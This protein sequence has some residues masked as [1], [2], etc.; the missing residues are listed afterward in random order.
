MSLHILIL[1]DEKRITDELSEYLL[2]KKFTVYTTNDVESAY[3]VME[4]M[5]FDILIL[6]IK[7]KKTNGLEVLKKVKGLYP[8]I[9]VIM[10]TAHGDMDTVIESM[11]LGAI[12]FLNKPFTHSDVQVAIERIGKFVAIQQKLNQVEE[13]NSLISMELEQNIERNLVGKSKA[14]KKVL[15]LALEAAKHDVNVLITGESGT[16]KEIIA[17]IIHFASK[18]KDHNFFPI[19]CSAIPET[20]VESEF[21]GHKKG[22]FTGAL[23]DKKGFFELTDGGTLFLDEIADMP[24]QLQAK[25]L[26]VIED[27]KIKRIG[28]EKEFGVDVRILAATN[29]DIEKRITENK[30][31]IDLYHRL[32]TFEIVIPPLRERVEDIEPLL[33]H[34]VQEFTKKSNIS[35]PKIDINL[36]KD[37]QNYDF[38][39]N[40]RELKNLTER[41]LI[42][43]KGAKLDRSY[44]PFFEKKYQRSSDEQDYDLERNERDMITSALQKA[45]YNQ[46]KAANLLGISRHT[47][48]RRINK[49]HIKT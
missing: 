28:Q 8:S 41:A 26:R 43:S 36:V 2:R 22:S 47:L 13:R 10:M 25:L 34:F 42:L 20:L 40:V 45:D 7:L 46:T 37:L 1:D 48:I 16:G 30:F 27:R 17:R 29:H 39:G 49:Y 14:I 35:I 3:K 24:L 9:E 33:H 32:N 11:R 15:E 18:R 5:Q 23:Q 21:F 6:D 38:P 31:R 12:D 4:D 44:F 19:N